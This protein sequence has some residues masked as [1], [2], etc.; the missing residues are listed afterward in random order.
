MRSDGGVCVGAFVRSEGPIRVEQYIVSI[1]RLGGSVSRPE[2]GWQG[3]S[4]HLNERPETM[5]LD[6]RPGVW[7]LRAPEGARSRPKRRFPPEFATHGGLCEIVRFRYVQV[8]PSRR[9]LPALWDASQSATARVPWEVLSHYTSLAF[10]P[11]DPG[12]S[13]Q[14]DQGVAAILRRTMIFDTQ[15]CGVR[16]WQVLERPLGNLAVR[17]ETS[18]KGSSRCWPPDQPRTNGPYTRVDISSDASA[19]HS[20]LFTQEHVLAFKTCVIRTGTR[21]TRRTSASAGWR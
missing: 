1:H 3:H 5:V 13:C 18:A 14:V 17:V 20:S 6:V 19:R 15:A 21:S 16:E 2:S 4:D 9:V 12:L 8:R 11:T 7:S 10:L